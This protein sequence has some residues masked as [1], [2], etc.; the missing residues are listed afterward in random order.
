MKKIQPDITQNNETSES[1]LRDFYI[2][3]NSSLL[4]INIAK[5]SLYQEIADF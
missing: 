1:I 3:V 2:K 5:H 4:Y